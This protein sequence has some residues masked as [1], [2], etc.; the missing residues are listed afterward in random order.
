MHRA[1][2]HVVLLV[3][4]T[5]LTAC[6]T[7]SVGQQ[8]C[9]AFDAAFRDAAATA[10][11]GNSSSSTSAALQLPGGCSFLTDS[12]VYQP[13]AVSLVLMGASNGTGSTW[14]TAFSLHQFSIEPGEI[15]GECVACSGRGTTQTGDT[16]GHRVAARMHAR[17]LASG[18]SAQPLQMH[19]CVHACTAQSQP[20]MRMRLWQSTTCMHALRGRA[21]ATACLHG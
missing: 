21:L 16:H 19:A 11:A 10:A 9:A 14:D 13:L 5:C 7:A 3:V 8:T 6:I 20:R 4:C 15:C 2:G 18:A 12:Y 17:W 1:C